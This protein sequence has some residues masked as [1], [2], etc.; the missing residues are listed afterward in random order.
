MR[1]ILLVFLALVAMTPFVAAQP[2]GRNLTVDD[3]FRIQRVSDPQIGP[4]GEW[5]AHTIGTTN[6]KEEKSESRIWMVP[7]TGGTPIPMTAVGSSASRP[8]FGPDGK[9]LAFLGMS[10]N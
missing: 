8:R 9:Y 1:K 10:R 3:Y 7:S 4:D 5:I 6:L 2:Q